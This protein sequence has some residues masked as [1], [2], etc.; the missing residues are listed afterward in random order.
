MN[1]CRVVIILIIQPT[2]TTM[3][4][5]VYYKWP[6]VLVEC[7]FTPLQKAPEGGGSMA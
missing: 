4:T 2:T 1:T 3:T 5:I 6:V 7:K